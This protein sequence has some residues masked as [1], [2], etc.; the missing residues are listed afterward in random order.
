MSGEGRG[1]ISVMA[2]RYGDGRV[3]LLCESEDVILLVLKLLL[4]LDPTPPPYAGDIR[5]VCRF[6]SVDV[7]VSCNLAIPSTAVGESAMF[8]WMCNPAVAG[9]WC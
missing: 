1:V 5:E 2:F 6:G 8:V 9:D 4:R 7:G 3:L